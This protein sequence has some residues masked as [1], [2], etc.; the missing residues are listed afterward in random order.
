MTHAYGS[1]KHACFPTNVAEIQQ[2]ARVIWPEEGLCS[3]GQTIATPAWFPC[4]RGTAVLFGERIPADWM[5][6]WA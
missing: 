6:S 5:W 1:L 4:D 2:R 3:W